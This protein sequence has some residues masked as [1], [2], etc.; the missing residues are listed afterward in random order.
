MNLTTGN[1][2]FGKCSTLWGISPR[3][4]K[5]SRHSLPKRRFPILLLCHFCYCYNCASSVLPQC[6]LS[7]A[8]E[9]LLSVGFHSNRDL[10][11]RP[12]LR[13]VPLIVRNKLSV[14]C[15]AKGCTKE[16][17]RL[18]L[19]HTFQGKQWVNLC[20]FEGLEGRGRHARGCL[21][22]K[23]FAKAEGKEKMEKMEKM[24]KWKK[25]N[26]EKKKKKK[27]KRGCPF[28]LSL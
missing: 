3:R 16:A 7:A 13:C 6:C 17:M 24:K 27:E 25:A 4:P 11:T 15:L 10:S 2:L 26:F 22:Q 21:T 19:L 8:I 28:I 14:G 12:F 23:S 9:V 18:T 20:A 5:I 1:S